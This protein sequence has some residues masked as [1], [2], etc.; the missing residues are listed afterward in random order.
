MKGGFRHVLTVEHRASLAAG[1]FEFRESGRRQ[2]SY[3]RHRARLV[4]ERLLRGKV[5]LQMKNL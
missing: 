2:A 1:A 5:R 3:R 4:A